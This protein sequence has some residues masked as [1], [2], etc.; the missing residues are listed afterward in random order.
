VGRGFF[1]PCRVVGPLEFR[2]TM[3]RLHLEGGG[4][5]LMVE[6]IVDG[7]SGERERGGNDDEIVCS[8]GRNLDHFPAM[9]LLLCICL[10]IFVTHAWAVEEDWAEFR[11]P[12]GQG[13]SQ[14][15]NVP[16]QWSATENIAWKVAVPGR[17]WSS[18]VLSKGRL[19]LTTAVGQDD[20]IS[21]RALCLDAKDGRALWNVEVFKPE[22]G[23]TKLM[24]RK[25]SLASPTPIVTA[26][27][28][29]VHFGHMG[30]AA[31]DLEGKMVWQQTS[32][33][34]LPVH[35]AG[36]SPIL[37]DGA[38]VF[39]CDGQS[40]PFIVALD[41]ATGEVRWKTPRQTSARKPFSFST[42]LA[43]ELDGVTQVISPTS[44]F[45]GSYDLKDGREL[46]RVNYVEGY[47]IVSRPVF[48]HGLVFVSTCFEKP[49]LKAIRPSGAK[50]DVTNTHLAWE[51]NK[52]VP[53]TPSMLVVCD[54]LYFVSDGG[55]ASCADA[56]TGKIHWTERLGGNFSASPMVAEGRI[57]F[58]NESGVGYVLKAGKKF[59]LLETNALGEP[60]LASPV[61]MDGVLFVRSEEHLWRIGRP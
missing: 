28:L 29:Y 14:A 3:R 15:V 27:R 61:P 19:Y 48:A 1:G 53:N 10:A 55:I 46:W 31:L 2:A 12:T 49:V 26:D 5:E 13:I 32:L 9:H 8:F 24:H 17:G 42:P 56:R 44:G 36:G 25:N 37:K 58:F 51:W 38:L 33:T 47:S 57:Y 23:A 11:G 60:T 21:L 6:L 41:A 50:G 20:A 40:D 54:E 39:S 45:V 30:T 34:Y 7:S 16:I 18:P 4:R 22:P 59:E 52:A 43:V 35:G